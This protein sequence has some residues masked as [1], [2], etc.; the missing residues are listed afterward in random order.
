[1]AVGRWAWAFLSP[2]GLCIQV[3]TQM[4]QYQIVLF[5]KP[6]EASAYELLCKFHYFF[7]T[8][9]YLRDMG[10]TAICMHSDRGCGAVLVVA[11]RQFLFCVLDC[12]GGFLLNE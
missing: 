1:M 6:T 4:L 12:V 9:Y 3:T 11:P 5:A 7:T 8:N 2:L 10:I